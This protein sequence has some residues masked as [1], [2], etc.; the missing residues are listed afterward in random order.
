M[1][2]PPIKNNNCVEERLRNPAKEIS[3][4]GDE[5]MKTPITLPMLFAP[6]L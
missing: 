5:F 2:I 4:N 3:L 1:A 6:K